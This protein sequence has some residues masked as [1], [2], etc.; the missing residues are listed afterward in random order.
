MDFYQKYKKLALLAEN[1]RFLYS[2]NNTARNNLLRL[3]AILITLCVLCSTSSIYLY[4]I[5]RTPLAATSLL[6]L[7]FIISVFRTKIIQSPNAISIRIGSHL[8]TSFYF[9]SISVAIPITGGIHS[10]LMGYYCLCPIIAD[11]L[12]NHTRI[13]IWTIASCFGVCVQIPLHLLLPVP[14][15]LQPKA[16]TLS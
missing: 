13:A 10:P 1:D 8:I 3:N 6:L 7:A 11:F 16:G 15:H 5:H 9:L 2:L 4:V 12:F 14:T